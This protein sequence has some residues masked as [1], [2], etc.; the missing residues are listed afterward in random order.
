MTASVSLVLTL[1]LQNT[2]T[3]LSQ[4]MLPTANVSNCRTGCFAIF[5]VTGTS[6]FTLEAGTWNV[7]I[8]SSFEES[9]LQ[10]VSDCCSDYY[11]KNI[12]K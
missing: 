3:V 9:S 6:E 4:G 5:Y 11:H 1:R 2:F 10:I 12:K 7:T 8:A